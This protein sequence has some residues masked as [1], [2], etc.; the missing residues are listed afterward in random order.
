MLISTASFAALVIFLIGSVLLIR[1]EALDDVGPFDEA[2]FL[3]AEEIDWQRRA[4]TR[5]WRVALCPDLVATHV[6]AGTGG[7]TLVRETHFHA[8]HERYIRKHF[9]TLGWWVYRSALL[10]GSAVRAVVLPGTRRHVAAVRF[11]LFREG[12]MQAESRLP[13]GDRRHAGDGPP[14]S[15]TD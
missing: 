4:A 11:S 3:Y 6:G 9:G 13:Q 2:F 15:P 1:A 14:N 5:G 8:S 12:P 7:D 10:T